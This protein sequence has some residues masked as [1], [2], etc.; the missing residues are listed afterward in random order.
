V[1]TI[2]N[3]LDAHLKQEV[4]TLCTCWKIVRKDGQTFGFTDH[5]QDLYFNGIV[6][7]C[8]T[9]YN[10]TA[11][12]SDEAMSVDNLNVTG[13]LESDQI[14]E[15]DLRNGLFDFAERLHLRGQLVQPHHGG[16]QAPPWLVRRSHRQ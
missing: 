10:R 14:S 12:T 13:F 5:D 6:Y 8:D 15:N 9:G 11:I 4:T 7:E 3:A 16:H 2:S 1:K